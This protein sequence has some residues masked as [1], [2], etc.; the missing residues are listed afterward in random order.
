MVKVRDSFSLMCITYTC[1]QLWLFFVPPAKWLNFLDYPRSSFLEMNSMAKSWQC[2]FKREKK[3]KKVKL[4]P[5]YLLV[6]ILD[7]WSKFV[8][9]IFTSHSC[10][11]SYDQAYFSVQET[12]TK[13]YKQFGLGY[14]ANKW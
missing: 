1:S 5:C 3:K 14:I 11:I 9:Y 13:I 6:T 8:I 2:V 4:P 7:P 12:E 10:T